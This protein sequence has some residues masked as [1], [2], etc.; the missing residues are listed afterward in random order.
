MKSTKTLSRLI[1]LVIAAMLI[2]VN[3]SSGAHAAVQ[4]VEAQAAP[5]DLDTTFGNGGKVITPFPG[6]TGAGGFAIAVV[7]PG[8]PIS[9][10]DSSVKFK[11]KIKA[12]ASSGPHQL[13]FR[14]KDDSGRVATATVTL[15]VQ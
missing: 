6:F 1:A 14:G 5:G 3:F 15:V 4:D 13:T 10:T 8:D 11:L 9:T 2:P 12:G 7:K